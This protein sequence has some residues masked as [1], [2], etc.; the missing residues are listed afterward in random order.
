MLNEPWLTNFDRLLRR[1]VNCVT[2]NPVYPNVMASASDDGTV[3]IWGPAERFRNRS[4]ANGNRAR[5]VN[6]VD[7]AECSTTNGV[8]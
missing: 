7:S 3:R 2:W 1:T 5:S 8:S 4:A 6:G